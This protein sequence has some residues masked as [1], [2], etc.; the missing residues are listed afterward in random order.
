MATRK[1]KRYMSSLVVKRPTSLSHH[2]QQMQQGGVYTPGSMPYEVVPMEMPG[3]SMP[4]IPGQNLQD[5]SSLLYRKQLLQQRQDAQDFKEQQAS[6]RALAASQANFLDLQDKLFGDVHNPW[7]EA[8]LA[9]LKS[10]YNI[11]DNI[12]SDVFQSPYR[13]KDLEFSMSQA[14]ASQKFKDIMGEVG[15]VTKMRDS[16]YKTLTEDEYREWAKAYDTYQFS[17]DGKYK[18]N[19][20]APSL[21]QKEKTYK[22]S[23]YATWMQTNYKDYFMQMDMKNPAHIDQVA[24]EVARGLAAKGQEEAIRRGYIEYVIPGDPNSGVM[25]TN[26]GKNFYLDQAEKSQ[27]IRDGK[28][29]EYVKKKRLSQQ[30]SQENR[31]FSDK[32]TDQNRTEK[33]KEDAANGTGGGGGGKETVDEKEARLELD[34]MGVPAEM[35]SE[36]LPSGFTVKDAMWRA[37]RNSNVPVVKKEIEDYLKKKNI[38]A[39]TK[40]SDPVLPDILQFPG[41]QLSPAQQLMQR[42]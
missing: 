15:T 7:Q 34:A 11:P 9:E 31:I 24:D 4:M 16:A 23:D 20:L 17:E 3:L 33:A 26:E 6:D 42:K 40:T 13:L 1:Q 22:D 12:T 35:R 2:V 28:W 27:A 19:D 37:V 21:Y 18:I 32:I 36:K 39:K 30:I 14:L 5:P 29:D 8:K 41:G 10:E 38:P 25:L